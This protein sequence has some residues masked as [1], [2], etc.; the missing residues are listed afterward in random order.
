MLDYTLSCWN[1]QSAVLVA[2]L[3]NQETGENRKKKVTEEVLTSCNFLS[4]SY[5]SK[6]L[7]VFIKL[8]KE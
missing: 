1:F 7:R 5:H 4:A 2:D 3:S 6:N 8:D